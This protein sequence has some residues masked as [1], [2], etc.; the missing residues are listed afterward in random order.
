MENG[1]IFMWMNLMG[2]EKNDPDKGVARYLDDTG[3]LPNAVCALVDHP[4]IIHDYRGMEEEYTLYPD[5]CSYHGVPR[6]II[7]ERQDWTNHDLRDLTANLKTAGS[8]LYLSIFGVDLHNA[9]HD[10]W[11]YKHPELMVH[12]LE[13]G[14]IHRQHY[15]LVKRFADGSYYED[16]FIDQLCKLLQET[17][18]KGV[19]LA[20]ALCPVSGCGFI[21]DYDYSTDFMEQFFVWTGITPPVEVAATMGTDTFETETLRAEWIRKEYRIEWTRFHCDRWTAFFKKLCDRLHAIDKK[22]IVLGMYCTDPFETVY[23]CGINLRDIVAAGVDYISANILPSS[24]FVNGPD[25]RGDPFHRLMAIAPLT[26]AHLPEKGHLVSMLALHDATEEWSA[27]HH[28]PTLHERDMFS[29]MSYRMIDKD[30][31]SRALDGFFLCLGD[32]IPR[33]DW[34]WESERLRLAFSAD[35]ESVVSPA[36]LWSDAAFDK[37]LPAYYHTRRWTPHKLFYELA[38]AGVHCAAAVRTDGLCNYSGTLVVPNFDLLTKDE[39]AMVAAYDRGAVVCTACPDFD[40]AAYGIQPEIV[41]KDRFSDYPLT[42]FVFHCKVTDQLQAQ[43]TSLLAEDDGTENLPAPVEYIQ[44]NTSNILTHTLTYAKVTKG[45]LQ[46]TALLLKSVQNCPF[47]ADKECIVLRLKNGAYRMYLLNDHHNKYHRAQVTSSIPV[48]DV[49]IVT[50]FPVLPPRFVDSFDSREANTHI[51]TDGIKQA[52]Q[53]F[54]VKIPPAGVV[55]LDIWE[56]N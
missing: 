19:H 35:A 20:D 55:V 38:Q 6:N 10:E 15:C 3:F 30:G 22:V 16:F 53:N 9:Y 5:N 43:L 17:G 31:I 24:S 37:M 2:F 34:D 18:A 44:E 33:S 32:G 50:K 14:H 49:K 45:L 39:Q 27:I 54:I 46:A 47:A 8:E 42:V 56:Q 40:P 51:F 23:C 21:A 13:D 25:D 52:K 7:R 41:L 36:M 4:D 1:N 28:A 48:K 29:M 12:F 26:A 11:I